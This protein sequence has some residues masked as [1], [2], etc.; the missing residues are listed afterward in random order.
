MFL[1]RNVLIL[2][3]TFRSEMYISTVFLIRN[4]QLRGLRASET[5]V[6]NNLGNE[7]QTNVIKSDREI[8]VLFPI[9]PLVISLAIGATT[10]S[11]MVT[12]TAAVWKIQL[13]IEVASATS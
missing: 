10:R 11:A 12:A 2:E 6:F 1:I 13:L 4:V 9:Y 3:R 8:R 7:A 5:Q